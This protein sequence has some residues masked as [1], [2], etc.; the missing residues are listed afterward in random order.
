MNTS[1]GW[2]HPSVTN[3]PTFS[4]LKHINKTLPVATP[5]YNKHT[6]FSMVTH[7]VTPLCNKHTIVIHIY[8]P[9][10]VVTPLYNKHTS[11]THI[12]KPLPVATPLCNKHTVVKHI[13]HFQWPH[14]SVTNIPTFSMVTHINH[15]QWPHPFVT[16]IPTFSIVTHI[17][18]PLQVA[19][20]LCNKT[21]LSFF[22]RRSNLHYKFCIFWV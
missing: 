14:P 4:M 12:Y 5:L 13:N 3:I 15:S 11:F 1:S 6:S 22:T 20:P 8:K 7:M 21:Y 18:K 9:L 2:P 17:Y 19:I 16:N 10:P